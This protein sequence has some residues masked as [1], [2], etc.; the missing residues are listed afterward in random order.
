MILSKEE[1][2]MFK[3]IFLCSNLTFQ[4]KRMGPENLLQN[5]WTG[6]W[7]FDQDREQN[8]NLN[9]LRKEFGH[10]IDFWSFLTKRTLNKRNPQNTTT[11]TFWKSQVILNQKKKNFQVLKIMKT[12]CFSFADELNP[13]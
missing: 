13:L 6:P 5:T 2:K 12:V 3:K 7:D 1:K 8:Q 4:E 10:E 11:L 9:R